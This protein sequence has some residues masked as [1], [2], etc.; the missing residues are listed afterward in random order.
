[1]SH[2]LRNFSFHRRL[3]GLAAFNLIAVCLCVAAGWFSANQLT[4][5]SED[6]GLSKDAV[7]DILPPPMYLIEMRLVL[8]QL[9]E[10]SVSAAQ[11]KA[12]I[13]RLSKEYAD[14]VAY[15][16]QQPSVPEPV[17]Q[18]LLGEQHQRALAFIAQAKA[19]SEMAGQM[20][21]EDLRLKIPEVNTLYLA[22]RQA[23]D[24]TVKTATSVAE[25]SLQAFA[26]VVTHSQRILAAVLVTS[27]VLSV[28]LFGLTIRSILQPLQ[29]SVDAVHRMATG[30]LSGDIASSGR[31]ELTTL[32]QAL[33][34]LQRALTDTVTVVQRN[35]QGVALTSQN[36]AVSN[37]DLSD[38]TQRQAAALQQTAATMTE[39]SEGMGHNA[40]SSRQAAELASGA[41][42]AASR[43]GAV[44]GEV[45][46]SI[47]DIQASSR[48]I[49]DIIGVID[50]IAFQTNILALNAAVEAARAGEQGRGFAVVASEVRS[51][52]QRSAEAAREIKRLIQS[53][54]EQVERG[55]QLVEAAGQAMDETVAAIQRVTEIIQSINTTSHQQTEG[56]M[57]VE[58]AVCQMD[59]GTQQNAALVHDSASTAAQLSD[60]AQVLLKATESFRLG[61]YASV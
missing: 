29:A 3:Q 24:A 16:Q 41:S 17:R 53:S 26:A 38:R 22:Q 51:L 52:A 15:W 4:R 42:T 20:G 21:S 44:M 49:G 34:A 61:R 2:W 36:I 27:V 33:Q 39:L 58:Q 12:E 55:T 35:A 31:D 43:S 54:G 57:Q 10:G 60:Q 28:L 50:G 48:Q 30:D 32:S 59:E 6:V 45:V 7:A 9:V 8:S 5:I 23:V 18:S 25:S 13:A 47:R 14:R 11:G 46:G 1:M 56:V 40:D 19:V 37:A